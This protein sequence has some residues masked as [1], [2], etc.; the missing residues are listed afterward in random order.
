MLQL[1]PVKMK[2]F[3]IPFA[4]IAF[5]LSA[6]V[7]SDHVPS[8]ERKIKLGITI[9]PDIAYRALE[10]NSTDPSTPLVINLRNDNEQPKL[11]YT[12][13]INILVPISPK[14]SFE[15]GMLYSDKGFKITDNDLFFPVPDPSLPVSIKHIYKQTFLDI[16]L[17]LN[18]DIGKGKMQLHTGVGI[19]AN[20]FLSDKI[21]QAVIYQD[22]H[23]ESSTQKYN[24][25]HELINISPTLSLGV[26]YFLGDHVML[27]IAPT[28]RYAILKTY[29]TLIDEHPW[30]AGMNMSY[31]F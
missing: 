16:P 25:D 12:T 21:K 7:I 30:S 3:L 27:R 11:G 24:V 5:N 23:E 1:D 15:S 19:T 13:G 8:H 22:G 29:G 20:I 9:S 2:L 18:F 14:L 31:Y 10:N 17:M 26:N 28:F 6:Q 4:F